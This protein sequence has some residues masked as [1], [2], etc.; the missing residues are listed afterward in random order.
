M[1][2]KEVL[3]PDDAITQNLRG[4]SFLKLEDFSPQELI[5]FFEVAR[6]LKEAQKAGQPHPLLAGKSL[7][8]IFRKTST[9]TRVSF[10]VG[11]YQLG[12]QALYLNSD[13]IQL[14]RGESVY[15][16]AMVLSR[17]VDGIMIRTFQQAEVEQLAQH[18]T[19]PVI[20]GLTDYCH[21]CQVLSDLFTVQEKRGCLRG[22]KL[23]YVGDGNNMAHSLLIGCSK[24]GMDVCIAHPPGYAP[25]PEIV[26]KAKALAEASDSAV[27][28]TT[29]PVAGVT[30]ADIIYTDVWTSMGQEAEEEQRIQAF[31][32]YQVNSAL[33]KH[34]KPDAVVMHCLPANRGQEITDEVMDGPQSI[35]FDQAENRLHVQKAIMALLMG[36]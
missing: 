12:G 9:R 15:D 34:A 5:R 6:N 20:N 31:G 17:Y 16:T 22:L 3:I 23:T 18:A 24:L 8:M 29:D 10:E 19:V 25:L 35:V 32:Q 26:A 30:G 11:I 4:R 1:V 33:L 14:G 36:E 7:A 2:N 13:D 28:L 21:P 27:E